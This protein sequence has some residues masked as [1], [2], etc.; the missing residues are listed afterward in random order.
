[1]MLFIMT[2]ITILKCLIAIPMFL[3][4]WLVS[5]IKICIFGDE[6]S[7]T[8]NL[9]IRGMSRLLLFVVFGFYY[10]PT[11][12]P[13]E[14]LRKW[15]KIIT[16]NHISIYDALIVVYLTGSVF[17][18]KQ[19]LKSVPVVGTLMRALGCV[20]VDRSTKSARRELINIIKKHCENE[21]NPP[22]CIFPQGTNSNTKMLTRFKPGAFI[23][24][25][26]C[27]PTVIH[28][29]NHFCDLTLFGGLVFNAFHVSCQ[30]INFARIEFLEI[31]HP[32]PEEMEDAALYALNVQTLIADKLE[33]EISPHSYPDLLITEFMETLKRKQNAELDV[34]Q[35][36]K[37]VAALE[38]APFLMAEVQQKLDMKGRTV[39]ELTK[40]FVTHCNGH[41]LVTL[42]MFIDL[43]EID[44]KEHGQKLFRLLTGGPKRAQSNQ[45]VTPQD[46]CVIHLPSS[47]GICLP[48][49]LV[50]VAICIHPELVDDALILFFAMI[51]QDG[52]HRISALDCVQ[53]LDKVRNT[54]LLDHTLVDEME[55]F[56][57][58]FEADCSQIFG[59]KGGPLDFVQFSKRIRQH[60]MGE[61]IQA[62]LRLVFESYVQSI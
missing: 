12:Y 20:F 54:S 35:G 42:D 49:F 34:L 61:A 4:T 28:Y 29:E 9:F 38:Q 10:I 33:A 40:A 8:F 39:V 16:P 46:H 55:S 51:D 19:E 1:M 23:P 53:F 14:H 58:M 50:A 57:Q 25:V 7:W 18:S 32:T 13:Q 22:L 59:A 5:V 31:Y 45:T 47:S 15:P 27:L 41:G 17:V 52:D 48:D 62:M 60:N 43:C 44:N 37:A 56:S 30:F 3:I 36:L 6:Y 21:D 11:K 2:T 24:G 26:A